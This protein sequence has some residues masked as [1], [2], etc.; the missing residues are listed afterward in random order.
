MRTPAGRRVATA[1]VVALFVLVGGAGNVAA[2]EAAAA[3]PP[4]PEAS[5]DTKGAAHNTTTPFPSSTEI[6]FK[7]AYVF[8]HGEDRYR[9]EVVVEP[10][11]R[12]EGFVLPDLHVNGFG[13]I[14]RFQLPAT[15]L[16]NNNGAAGGLGDLSF[17]D[18][19]VRRIGPLECGLGFASVFPM[20]TSPELGSG[21]WQLGPAA[22]LRVH[23]V[24]WLK[25]A[26]LTQTLW[27]VAGSSQS[28]NLAY[29]TVQPFFAVHF[30]DALFF[31]SDATM[32]F[33]WAGGA[34]KLPVNLGFGGALSGHFTA[35]MFGEYTVALADEGDVKALIKLTYRP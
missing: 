10:R 30:L 15:S 14:A 11:F 16:E 2:E 19:V 9:A 3:T 6:A 23:T 13:S 25:L 18:V 7:P 4:Q 1:L 33:D 35:A 20:A 29:E 34:S 17:V 8:P 12:Y 27:S 32:R 26:V 5:P 31:A 22:G 24:P 21:K 28:P